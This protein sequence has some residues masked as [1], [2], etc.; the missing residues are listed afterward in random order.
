[1][2]VSG[3]YTD[4]DAIEV[5]EVFV[6][7]PSLL[8]GIAD[9][10][11]ALWQYSGDWWTY[12]GS[13]PYSNTIHI[14]G[15]IGDSAQIVISGGQQIK[16]TY[17]MASNRGVT[18]VYIDGVKVT[19]IDAYSPGFS[20]EKTW[21]S[22][23]LTTGLHMVRLVHVSGAYTDIDAIEVFATPP[24]LLPGIADDSDA[25]WQYSGDWSTY[26]GSGPYLNTLHTSSTIGDSAQIM[27]SGGQQIK[28][29]YMT[30]S[31]RGVT[32]VYID[33]IK[34]ASIDAYSLDFNW[35]TTWTSDILTTGPHTVRLVHASGA[36]IDIDSLEVLP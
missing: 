9:D 24:S 8:P 12:N 10:G 11:D 26:N 2:H 29:T 30:F 31:N 22:D 6:A 17:L 33:G 34:V 7:P 18:D 23:V 20:W 25:L 15:T 19:S 21:S 32:D 5:V 36:Y 16:L 14:S 27:I 13:G 3:A 1:V 4:I 28:L 35:G